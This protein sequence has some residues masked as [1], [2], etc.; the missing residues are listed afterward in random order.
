MKILYKPFGMIAAFIAAR[1][2]RSIFKGLWSKI[3]EAGPPDPT[4]AQATFP[5]VVGAA[6]LEAATMAG[7]GA[8][9]DRAAARTF[10]HLTGFWPGNKT[11]PDSDG[12]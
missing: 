10:Y 5:K 3:D 7:V 9:A 8:A 1:I 6:A 4:T 2:G 11:E 12:K